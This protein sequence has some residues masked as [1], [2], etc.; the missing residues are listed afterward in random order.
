MRNDVHEEIARLG[1]MTVGELQ[2]KYAAVY[3]EPTRSFNKP[4]LIKRIAWG[5][6]A[7]A[8]GGLS[9][10]AKARAAELARE[11]DLRMSAP[12]TAPVVIASRFAQLSDSRLPMHGTILKRIYKG[13]TIEVLVRDR[14]FEFEGEVYRS[15]SAIAKKITGAHWNGYLFFGMPRSEAAS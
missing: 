4:Y 2:R 15:L 5:L 7:R 3:E 6:Q 13:Q 11:I 14:G 1:G 8:E 10:R 12:K 9:D